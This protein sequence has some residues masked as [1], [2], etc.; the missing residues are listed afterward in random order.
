[1]AGLGMDR[2]GLLFFC[3]VFNPV[4]DIKF[5]RSETETPFGGYECWLSINNK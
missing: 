5:V 2:T 4:R 1:V 3:R